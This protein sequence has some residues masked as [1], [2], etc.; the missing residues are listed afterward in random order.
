M[1]VNGLD[2]ARYTPTCVGKTYYHPC[3]S[4]SHYG[5]PPR[6]WG[7]RRDDET[8]FLPVAV[9]PHVC[10]ENQFARQ[11]DK[12]G[13][14]TPPRVWGKRSRCMP[15]FMH[16]RY[17]PTCVGKTLTEKTPKQIRTVHPHVCGE[18]AKTAGLSKL[19]TGTPPRVWG[20]RGEMNNELGRL[21]YTPTCVGKTP[22]LAFCHS[23]CDGTP[24]RVWGKPFVLMKGYMWLFLCERPDYVGS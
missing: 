21:R 17:T 8:R 10:G 1:I 7:K 2:N 5:T 22:P 13:H 15:R 18:N 9:H 14:G 3:H 11:F 19:C 24:P 20:K 6:V 4:Y 12:A 23:L 16:F